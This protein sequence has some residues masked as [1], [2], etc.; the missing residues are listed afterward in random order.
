MIRD[1]F[2]KRYPQT[3]LHGDRVPP[4][5]LRLLNQAAQI[6]LHDLGD[7]VGDR[8]QYFEEIHWELSRELG[9]GLLR[10]GT[11][12]EQICLQYLTEPYHLFNSAHDTPDVFFKTRLSMVELAF[13]KAE[14]HGQLMDRTKER[15]K[16]PILGGA[17]R[18]PVGKAPLPDNLPFVTEA[19]AEL[20]TR[21]R[22]AQARLSYH[23]GLIQLVDDRVTTEQIE[24][25]F[26]E[27][28][29]DAKW[30]NVDHD[31]K[32]A[33]DR[34]DS[35]KGDAAFYALKALESVVKVISD[36][37][38]WTRG[39]E[40]GAA[41]YIDNLV[42]NKNGRFIDVWEA[43]ALKQLFSN[44]RNPHGHGPGGDPM[45]SL[46]EYQ[47]TCV[48]EVAMAWIKSLVRRS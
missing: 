47:S 13:R 32:E 41:S 40:R 14:Q 34:R 30:G 42:S 9:A 45:P 43:E 29:S 27:L 6:I 31:M 20:N 12:Y 21:F 5:L 24:M 33:V 22:E 1:V 37:R 4:Q 11:Q 48:I 23:N 39:T 35:G 16:K 46:A 17:L 28:V 2:A 7:T 19:I 38:G 44:V 36:E 25:P 8:S 18:V 26:W 15:R 3:L 10:K